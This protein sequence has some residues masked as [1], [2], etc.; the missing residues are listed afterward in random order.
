MIDR[1]YSITNDK[2][3]KKLINKI[4]PLIVIFRSIKI[5]T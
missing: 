1:L 2:L 3:L 5:D 4:Q